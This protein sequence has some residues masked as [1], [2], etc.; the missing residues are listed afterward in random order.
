MRLP[1]LRAGF[2]IQ[3]TNGSGMA[4]KNSIASK[5]GHARR[6]FFP[7]QFPGFCIKRN[8]SVVKALYHYS[9][10]H[11]G[12]AAVKHGTKIIFPI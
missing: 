2:Y 6:C 7:K 4:H 10:V 11:A 9:L 3:G 1:K 8:G 12:N 5:I